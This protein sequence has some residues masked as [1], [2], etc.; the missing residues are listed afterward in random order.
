MWM[1][2]YLVPLVAWELLLWSEIML[3][4]LLRL[5]VTVSDMSLALNWLK[6]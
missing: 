3:V 4:I 6:L 5:V 1:R 2:H